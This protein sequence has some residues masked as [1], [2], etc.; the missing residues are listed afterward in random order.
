MT[1][2]LSGEL[3]AP[4]ARYGNRF[5]LEPAPDERLPDNG[6]SATDAMR[7]LGEDLALDGMPMRNLA[8]S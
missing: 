5:L 7:L 1:P 3:D 6:M 8:R 2:E 4:T